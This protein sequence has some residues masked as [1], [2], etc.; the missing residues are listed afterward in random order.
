MV[1]NVAFLPLK[2]FLKHMYSGKQRQRNDFEYDISISPFQIRLHPTAVELLICYTTCSEEEQ[3]FNFYSCD[4]WI[5]LCETY[6]HIVCHIACRERYAHNVLDN[7]RTCWINPLCRSIWINKDQISVIDRKCGSIK[8]IIEPHWDQFRK[9][10]LYWSALI[11]I[12]DWS[13]MSWQ[14]SRKN[15][16]FFRSEPMNRFLVSHC[17]EANGC[18][19]SVQIHSSVWYLGVLKAHNQFSERQ[20]W[21]VLMDELVTM[22]EH[23]V[24]WT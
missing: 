7:I 21:G 14:N 13:S 12:G 9:S 16:A 20:R 1:H 4:L 10:D 17:K 18:W 3:W 5:L 19:R 8:I 2:W 23:K 11:G 6:C 24:R 22:T 15:K